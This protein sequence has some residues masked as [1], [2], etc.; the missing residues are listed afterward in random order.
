[1]RHGRADTHLTPDGVFETRRV[2]RMAKERGLRAG[3]ML[4][5]PLP[6][7]I[8]TAEIA[9]KVFG[10]E[11][12]ISNSIEP[13]GSPD[14][15]YEVLGKYSPEEMILLVSHKP[16]VTLLVSDLTGE[17]IVFD[18]GMLASVATTGFPEKANGKL[19]MLIPPR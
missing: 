16:L 17:E 11:Y 7:A 19:V 13:E 3:V 9:K 4:S 2:L 15:V 14:G 18:P 12:S 10:V 1:M 8:E 6:R 5:S